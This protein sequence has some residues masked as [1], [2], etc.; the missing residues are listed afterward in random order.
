MF[1]KNMT[2]H[3][4]RPAHYNQTVFNYK[5]NLLVGYTFLRATIIPTKIK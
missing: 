5:R 3:I 1:E 2:G 4:I